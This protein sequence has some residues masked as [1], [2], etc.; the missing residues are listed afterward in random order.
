M[1]IDTDF[2]GIIKTFFIIADHV[3][4]FNIYIGQL[5]N[6]SF[7]FLSKN[8]TFLKEKDVHLKDFVKVGFDKGLRGFTNS[9]IR[10][11]GIRKYKL[12]GQWTVKTFRIGFYLR[13]Q[14]PTFFNSSFNVKFIFVTFKFS[15]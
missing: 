15:I 14:M 11:T 8:G 10:I 3:E 7:D 1:D 4:Y 5:I 2:F 13:I 9:L 12:C 6:I